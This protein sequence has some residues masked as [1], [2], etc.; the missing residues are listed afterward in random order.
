MTAVLCL[1]AVIAIAGGADAAETPADVEGGRQFYMCAAFQA[2]KI[3]G[4]FTANGPLVLAGAIGGG[5]SCGL[6]W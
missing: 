6:G 4:L 5:L 2:V 3:V 1:V